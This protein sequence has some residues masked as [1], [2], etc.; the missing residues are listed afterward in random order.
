MSGKKS[1]QVRDRAQHAADQVKPLADQ[2]KPLARSTG[3]AARRNVR[4]SRAWAAPRVERTGQAL[5]HTVAP[6]I[7]S[8]LSTA[9]ERID[10]NKPK[11]G[12]WRLP[13]GIAAALAGAAGA[14]A[15]AIRRRTPPPDGGS[16]AVTD[17]PDML[18]P[19]AGATTGD[20]QARPG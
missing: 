16:T 4:R 10:P 14:G 17:Q 5:Q 2:L 3:E 1:T 19:P 11:R 8:M 20:G 15:A 12:R 13:V 7:S 9:A 18:A 6:K